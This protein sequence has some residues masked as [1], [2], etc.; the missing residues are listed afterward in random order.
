M[1]V[2]VGDIPDQPFSLL[3]GLFTGHADIGEKMRIVRESA[4]HGSLAVALPSQA[5]AAPC[6][7]E[8]VAPVFLMKCRVDAAVHVRRFGIDKL[9]K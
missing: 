7:D 6:P 5:P 3:E 4:K 1:D 8:R 9:R 2:N